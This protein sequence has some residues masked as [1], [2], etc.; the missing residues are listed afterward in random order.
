MWTLFRQK[1]KIS[2][3]SILTN[4]FRRFFHTH[5]HLRE[6]DFYV[7]SCEFDS[8]PDRGRDVLFF[9]F[10]HQRSIS[11]FPVVE[12]SSSPMVTWDA[13]FYETWKIWDLFFFLALLV[14][15]SVAIGSILTFFRLPSP[16]S[17]VGWKVRSPACSCGL[18]TM[19]PYNPFL[20]EMKRIFQMG[21]VH[22]LPPSPLVFLFH[23]LATPSRR[24]INL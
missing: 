19:S 8:L 21:G 1:K 9:F 11:D 7:C 24:Q 18:S 22:Y 13:S 14:F 15:E 10:A 5:M 23:P 20:H 12:Q 4:V 16:L 17:V 6:D 2:A 3:G